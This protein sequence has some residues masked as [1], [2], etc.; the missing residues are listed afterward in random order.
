MPKQVRKAMLSHPSKQIND[1][2]IHL[3]KEKQMVTES[4]ETGEA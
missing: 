3:H 1:K 2:A 4:D